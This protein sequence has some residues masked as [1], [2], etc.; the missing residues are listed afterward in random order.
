MMKS[1]IIT[2]P[3]GSGKTH[4]AKAIELSL[5]PEKSCL[6]LAGDELE[7][8]KK[9]GVKAKFFKKHSLVII[10][11]CSM[12]DICVFNLAYLNT[13]IESKCTIVYLTRDNVW[14]IPKDYIWVVD[15]KSK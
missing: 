3:Q 11:E 5:A 2:G 15:L 7:R 13:S 4:I 6:V 8:I 14:R 9:K 12:N 1:I 10:D